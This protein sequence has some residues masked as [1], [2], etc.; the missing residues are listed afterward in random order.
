[1]RGVFGLKAP[2]TLALSHK[3]RGNKSKN[4]YATA[5]EGASRKKPN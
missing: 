2:L 1:V 3:G 4:T 5:G